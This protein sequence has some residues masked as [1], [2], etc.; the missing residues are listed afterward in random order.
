[1]AY[2]GRCFELSRNRV[3]ARVGYDGAGAGLGFVSCT[4]ITVMAAATRPVQ[5]ALREISTNPQSVLYS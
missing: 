2:C 3:P 4:S 1:M 5:D